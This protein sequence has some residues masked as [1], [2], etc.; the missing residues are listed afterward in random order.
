M[1]TNTAPIRDSGLVVNK[2]KSQQKEHSIQENNN[3]NMERAKDELLDK[4]NILQRAACEYFVQCKKPKHIFK[5]YSVIRRTFFRRIEKIKN[6]GQKVGLPM[7]EDGLELPINEEVFRSLYKE[8]S[9]KKT[10]K[11]RIPKNIM[12]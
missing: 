11:H 2:H 6:K 9:G 8:I 1:L 5:K 3:V 7:N 12:S 4:E 10:R